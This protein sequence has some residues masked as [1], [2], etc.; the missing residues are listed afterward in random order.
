VGQADAAGATLLDLSQSAGQIGEVVRLITDIA[1]KT[2]LLALNATIEAA[3]AGEAGRGFSVV[4]SEVKQLARQT[5]HATE[6]I[7][8][9]VASIQSA[10][11]NAVEAMRGVGAAIG[12]IDEVAAAIAA[13]VTAQGSTAR[14]IAGSVQNVADRNTS[15]ID[16]LREALELAEQAGQASMGVI[17]AAE[18]NNL[19]AHSLHADVDYFLTALRS[20]QGEQRAW[21]RV[22]AGGATV[23][24]R[25]AEG[26]LISASLVDISRGGA[27]LACAARLEPGA[28][29]ELELPAPGGSVHARVVRTDGQALALTFRQDPASLAKIDKVLARLGEAIGRAA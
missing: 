21:E 17:G 12:Q 3:R 7:S 5:A 2:N 11:G 22:E 27:M 13:A 20:S 15:A 26:V 24:V 14:D 10:T 6:Q 4:A 18:Q 8:T 25:P 19:I 16:A 29:I 1:A 28:D 23:S 9:Q